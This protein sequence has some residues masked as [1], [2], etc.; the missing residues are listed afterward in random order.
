MLSTV[1]C[2]LALGAERPAFQSL[3][4]NGDWS[5]LHDSSQQADWLDPVKFIPLHGTNVYV[6]LGGEARLKYEH[7]DVPVFNRGGRMIPAG[8]L[9]RCRPSRA[10]SSV[11]TLRAA[12]TVV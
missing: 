10:H 9:P 11:L 12:T 2:A 4:Y 8:P 5:L 1:M 6:S 3:P 7:Y